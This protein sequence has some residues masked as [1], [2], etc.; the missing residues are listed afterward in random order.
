MLAPMLILFVSG[1]SSNRPVRSS[2]PSEPTAS[3]PSQPPVV[4]P[5]PVVGIAVTVAPCCAATLPARWTPPQVEDNT[6]LGSHDPS[7][8]LSVTWQV[9]GRAGSCP[10][11]PPALLD[12]L[13]SPSHPSGDVIIGVDPFSVDGKHVTLYI[14]TPDASTTR[15][16]E[17]VNADAVIGTDCVDLG[18]AEYGV[19][20]TPNLE[21]VLGI[22]ATTWS[23]VYPLQ[24][25]HTPSVG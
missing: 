9:V 16:F 23:I 22:L 10:D 4:A 8:K 5:K 20:S 24:P 13:Y 7:G 25:S 2:P 21:M 1:C 6:L 3:L 19:A 11:E 18:G 15:A 14:T 17:F 12:S